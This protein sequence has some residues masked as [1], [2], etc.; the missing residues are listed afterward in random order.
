MTVSLLAQLWDCTGSGRCIVHMSGMYQIARNP[1]DTNCHRLWRLPRRDYFLL[2]VIFLTTIVV[3][4]FGG[5]VAAR[6]IYVQEA[7]FE[8][9]ESLTTEGFRYQPLCTSHTKVWEGP[10]ITQH[11]NDC[12]Y[13]SAESCAPRPAGSLRVVVVGSS[14]ARGA[15]VNYPESFAGRAEATLSQRCGTPVDFQNLGTEPP[16]VARIPQRMPEVLGLK[17]DAIVMMIGPFDLVHLKD[18]PPTPGHLNDQRPFDLRFVM[19]KLRE[20]RLFEL[21]QFYLYRDPDFQARAFLL[22]GDN[23]DYLRTPL[24]AAWRD[25]VANFADLLA[26]IAP[27]SDGVP[28]LLAYVPERGHVAIAKMTNRPA[29]V[30]PYLLGEALQN[31]AKPYGIQVLDMTRSMASV[32]DFQS[33]FYATEGHAQAGGHAAMA[34]V[35]ENA[36]LAEPAFRRCTQQ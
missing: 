21:M 11:F 23:V 9:C 10:W 24:S 7:D 31:V 17:P 15:L 12:G 1:I 32:P 28:I 20:S 29:N 36:L 25:R 18:P 30:D 22:N 26:Q 13:R 19:N 4:L 3:L 5:E 2:P 33:L 16:D 6:W 34:T 27:R 14:T 35:V 8:P